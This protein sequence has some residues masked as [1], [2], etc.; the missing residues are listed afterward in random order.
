MLK[1]SILAALA[2][3]MVWSALDFVIHG[4]ILKSTYE[5]TAQLWRPMTEMKMG[6]MHVAVL[7]AAVAFVSIYARLLARRGV[8]TGL[9][10]GLWFGLA[11]G[12]SMGYGTYSV[13]PI[14]YH[15]ALT[16]FLGSL[17]QGAVGGV[18]TGW[19]VRD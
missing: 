12:V 3:F 9:Q 2:V 4:L 6:V 15:M 18:I 16:W 11:T 14:P 13:M 5:A 7:I 1:K 19:I 10:Y 8:G 17:V